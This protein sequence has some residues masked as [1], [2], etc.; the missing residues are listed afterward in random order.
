VVP[1]VQ[2][3]SSAGVESATLTVPAGVPHTTGA[4]LYAL[5][6][7]GEGTPGDPARAYAADNFSISTSEDPVA[8]FPTTAPTFQANRPVDFVDPSSTLTTSAP[9]A[10]VRTGSAATLGATTTLRDLYN[11]PI[12]AKQVSIYPALGPLGGHVVAT[13]QSYPSNGDAYSR[14][15]TTA[16]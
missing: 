14:R 8:G 7:P 16:P 5:C 3:S 11:N 6:R 15:L 4:V 1:A 13:P 12:I 10:T 2:T 9:T